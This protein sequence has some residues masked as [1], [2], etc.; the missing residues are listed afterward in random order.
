[1]QAGDEEILM[2]EANVGETLTYDLSNI[3]DQKGLKFWAVYSDGNGTVRKSAV[4]TD[5][6]LARVIPAQM[7]VELEDRRVSKNDAVVSLVD[8]AASLS[9]AAVGGKGDYVAAKISVPSAAQL[10]VRLRS[11]SAEG[12]VKVTVNGTEQELT[13]N[14]S[15]ADYPLGQ[16]DGTVDF[17]A[18]NLGD[19]LVYFD[20]L[21]ISGEGIA[22]VNNNVFH[23]MLDIS[24]ATSL[25]SGIDGTDYTVTADLRSQH[26]YA[27]TA[28]GGFGIVFDNDD[29]TRYELFYDHAAG[30]LLIRQQ[31]ATGYTTI[32]EAP[33]KLESGKW[34]K[35]KLELAGNNVSAK[36][37]EGEEPAAWTITAALPKRTVGSFGLIAS[38]CD[39]LADNVQVV[40]GGEV[41]YNETMEYVMPGS[42]PSG[43]NSLR[44][45][46]WQVEDKR[47][48][49]N[50]E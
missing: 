39:F 16:Y 6:E 46:S 38:R 37:W 20:K 35:A 41:V 3:A 29:V 11:K 23:H 36:I 34:Y 31:S 28:E 26:F 1:M 42:R 44:S 12:K 24:N 40:S 19:E 7:R 9:V 15:Y 43:S 30:K 27:P 2:G 8:D 18:E 22:D 50:C 49:R 13:V 10:S 48:L 33:L 5:V 17:R 25:L 45:D 32:A 14:G 47:A 21:S 4:C